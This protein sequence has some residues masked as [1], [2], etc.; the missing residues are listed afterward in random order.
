VAAGDGGCGGI[1]CRDLYSVLGWQVQAL[2]DKGGI[3]LLINLALVVA[4]LVL[5]WPA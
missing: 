4:V 5:K 2:N 1:V 3:G